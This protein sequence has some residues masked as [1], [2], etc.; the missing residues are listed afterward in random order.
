MKIGPIDTEIAL[1]IKKINKKTLW[2][3]KYIARSASLLSGLN[4]T[5]TNNNNNSR[6]LHPAP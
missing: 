5:T 4:N 1:L 6:A 3:V 2:K